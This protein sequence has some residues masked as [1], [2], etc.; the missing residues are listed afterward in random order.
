MITV[1]SRAGRR[2]ADLSSCLRAIP[3]SVVVTSTALAQRPRD[4]AIDAT[5]QPVPVETG[6]LRFGS[7]RSPDGHTIEAT[8]RYLTRDGKPWL[9]VMG[10]FHFSRYPEGEW[11]QEL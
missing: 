6:F 5:S 8:S 1:R 2:W 10:E 11:E 4:I 3:I 7:T 9:P